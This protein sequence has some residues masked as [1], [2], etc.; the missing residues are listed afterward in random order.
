MRPLHPEACF[1]T[2]Q[3][4]GVHKGF[5]QSQAGLKPNLNFTPISIS[6]MPASTAA[7]NHRPSADLALEVSKSRGRVAQG[8]LFSLAG[9]SPVE[10][11][12]IANLLRRHG[13]GKQVSL[14]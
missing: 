3:I 2:L 8:Y 10:L 9:V 7:S 12:E 14:G 13:L 1:D 11:N 6:G 4:P 5:F